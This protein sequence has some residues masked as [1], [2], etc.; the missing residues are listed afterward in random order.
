MCYTILS[1]ILSLNPLLVEF[2]LT[3]SKY[4][5][6]TVLVLDGICLS[7]LVWVVPIGMVLTATWEHNSRTFPGP[8]NSENFQGSYEP[9]IG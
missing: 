8:F 9:C 4:E 1:I 2:F 5:D 6:S 7:E 3:L